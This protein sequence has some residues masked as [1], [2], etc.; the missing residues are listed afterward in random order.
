MG[1]ATT[2]SGGPFGDLLR[3]LEMLAEHVGTEFD[4]AQAWA[5]LQGA[6]LC[7]DERD[8]WVEAVT[9][10]VAR[11]GLRAQAVELTAAERAGGRVAGGHST[12]VEGV[13]RQRRLDQQPG[14]RGRARRRA[15]D[16]SQ[17]PRAQPHPRLVPALDQVTLHSAAPRR[18]RQQ[19]A[20]PHVRTQQRQR[21]HR[22]ADP[23]ARSA[24]CAR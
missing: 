7:G 21:R 9:R 5:A 4:P 18:L 2:G 22:R 14:R 24:A 16:V 17:R 8:G 20:P 11:M 3:V 23:P 10:A 19:P 1:S 15:E 13:Q 12:R 6:A